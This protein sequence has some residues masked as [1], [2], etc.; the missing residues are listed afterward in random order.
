MLSLIVAAFLSENVR[1][2]T[3]EVFLQELKDAVE[4]RA[5]TLSNLYRQW[6]KGE[7]ELHMSESCM[8]E[9]TKTQCRR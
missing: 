9:S 3:L 6:K 7:S 2:G 5:N 1:T 4:A 8:H